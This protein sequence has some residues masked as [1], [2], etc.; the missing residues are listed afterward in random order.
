MK[1]LCNFSHV[2][3]LTSALRGLIDALGVCLRPF[4]ERSQLLITVKGCLIQTCTTN[5]VPESIFFIDY[6]F[7]VYNFLL[8]HSFFNILDS[9]PLFL[10]TIIM[11]VMWN[12]SPLRTR[13]ETLTSWTRRVSTKVSSCDS[14]TVKESNYE[15]DVSFYCFSGQKFI[16]FSED[17]NNLRVEI[18]S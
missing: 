3:H 11:S 4:V 13:I 1:K 14:M 18:I 7:R 8:Y 16:V 6:Y 17:T 12:D 10:M 5:H 9:W 15:W 2:C